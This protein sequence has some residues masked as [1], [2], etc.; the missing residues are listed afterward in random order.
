M[1]VSL[2]QIQYT[3]FCAVPPSV[4]ASLQ[5]IKRYSICFLIVTSINKVYLYTRLS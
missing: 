1:T 5:Q 3:H 2:P 4:H